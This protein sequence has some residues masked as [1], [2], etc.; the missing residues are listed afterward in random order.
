MAELE[1]EHKKRAVS[2]HAQVATDQ[3]F[4]TIVFE[5][6]GW[7]GDMLAAPPLDSSTTYYWRVRGQNLMGDGKWSE[8]LSFMTAN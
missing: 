3:G 6:N 2:Y 7:T 8:T 1:W 4:K 5:N